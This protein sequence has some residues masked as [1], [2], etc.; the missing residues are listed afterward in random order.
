MKADTIEGNK[1]IAVFEG[2]EVL[3]EFNDPDAFNK[4][5]PT[6]MLPA[7]LFYETDW[8]RLIK[9][10]KKFRD[11]DLQSPEYKAWVQEIDGSVTDNYD[12]ANQ[13]FPTVVAAITWYNNQTKLL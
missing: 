6:A 9:S 4:L 13:A 8:N 5:S 12:I 11:L 10:I 7:Q 3:D 1:L 2:I